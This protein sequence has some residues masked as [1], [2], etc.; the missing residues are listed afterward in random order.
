[1]EIFDE[2]TERELLAFWFPDGA[3]EKR[4]LPDARAIE[5]RLC[6]MANRL[7]TCNPHVIAGMRNFAEHLLRRY[8]V[9]A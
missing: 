3:P 8:G 1:M 9:A 6:A 5:R 4:G 2:K 7:T